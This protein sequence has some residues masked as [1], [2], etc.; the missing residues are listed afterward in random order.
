[1][2]PAPSPLLAPPVPQPHPLLQCSGQP[3]AA[4]ATG[5]RQC[6][7]SV[8]SEQMHCLPF[9]LAGQRQPSVASAALP[10]AL[11]PRAQYSPA[12]PA[13]QLLPPLATALLAQQQ[14]AWATCGEQVAW[15]QVGCGRR[16]RSAPPLQSMLA[17]GRVL[18]CRQASPP[19]Q[20]A[21][22]CNM[23]HAAPR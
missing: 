5:D 2:E 1:M 20:A 8:T 14:A 10:P 4:S 15:T 23:L 7:G 11:L 21:A 19:A 3:V 12:R 9:Q 13:Q 17:A 6:S 16:C 22:M 18:A